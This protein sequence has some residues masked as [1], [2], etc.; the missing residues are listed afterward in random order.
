M[1][2]EVGRDPGRTV[3]T[4]FVV[5]VVGQWHGVYGAGEAWHSRGWRP[6]AGGMQLAE[7]ASEVRGTEAAV[8]L[9]AHTTVVTN[10]GTKDCGE[11]EGP[12]GQ[13]LSWQAPKLVQSLTLLLHPQGYNSVQSRPALSCLVPLPPML[14]HLHWL[15]PVVQTSVI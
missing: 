6:G 3:L 5:A 11:S 7:F 12:Q 8:R 2:R 14:G 13:Q 1:D 9:H 15:G 4:V 10:Q